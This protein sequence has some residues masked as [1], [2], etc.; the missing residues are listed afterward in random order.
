MAEKLVKTD[1]QV[2]TYLDLN[3]SR[4]EGGQPDPLLLLDLN[5]LRDVIFVQDAS[6]R[7]V[8]ASSSGIA[9]FGY[10]SDEIKDLGLTQLMQPDSL[11]R[12]MRKYKRYYYLA[13]K[14]DD[15][16][17]PL[18][19]YEYIRK[20]GSTF[21]AELKV[22]FIKDATGSIIGSQGILRNVDERKRMEHHLNQSNHKFRTL[23]D[24]SPQAIALT[25][26]DTGKIIEVNDKFCQLVKYRRDELIGKTT[27]HLGFYTAE[28]RGEFISKLY[29]WGH[30]KHLPMDFKIKDGSILNAQMFAKIIEAGNQS[31]LLTIF[32]DQTQEKLLERQFWQ[33]QKMESFGTLAG[34][35]AHDLNNFLMTIE[36]H[37]TMLLEKIET[38]HPDYAGLSAINAQVNSCTQLTG[39]LL[40]YARNKRNDLVF[41]DLN[42]IINETTSS[43]KK[44]LEKITISKELDQ[45]LQ[46][47]KGDTIQIRQ[48]LYNLFINAAE[49]MPDGGKLF[50]KTSTI[51][52]DALTG[53][54]FNP[55]RRDYIALEVADT[56]V[57]MDWGTREHL[58]EAF[59]TTKEGRGTGL[60]LASVD[61]I[62]KAHQGQIEVESKPGRGSTFRIY[63]PA[64]PPKNAN[65]NISE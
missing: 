60:G 10:T 47:I 3:A 18:M 31:L 19:E 17:I 28:Q 35:I 4:L 52:Y 27:T 2:L 53:L 45:A 7:I 48:V 43:L 23:F 59:Y 1:G 15:I 21:W 24:L 42:Q 16:D 65:Q 61:G 64:A 36:G 13:L 58:F 55:L 50:I 14:E 39:Q 46:P 25:L 22:N 38:S 9:L 32:Y 26:I 11:E 33:A 30:V 41:F 40:G 63:F 57:G 44:A 20:D 29:K 8:Y 37:A 49:A 56:G 62:V 6:F 51:G 54:S 34:S 5:N 12:A